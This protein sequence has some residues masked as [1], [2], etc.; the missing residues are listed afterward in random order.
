MHAFIPLRSN[1]GYELW[2]GNRP[3]A[4][5]FFSASLHPNTNPEEFARL[6]SL[7][8]LAYMREKSTLAESAIRANPGRFLTLTGRRIVCFWTGISRVSDRNL[9][10]YLVT[11]AL[12]GFCGLIVLARRSPAH[13]LFLALPLILFPLPYYIT[14]PDPRFRLI[15]EPVLILL[16][17]HLLADLA[18]RIQPA[19][20]RP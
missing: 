1:F 3:G 17:A 6:Q 20:S 19:N 18:R 5:G 10:V 13:A 4:D 7:G 14:H 8:E 12:A 11:T 9:V 15:L 16:I 2:Q